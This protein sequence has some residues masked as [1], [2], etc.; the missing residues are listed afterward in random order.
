MQVPPSRL[1]PAQG[2]G[3]PPPFYLAMPPPTFPLLQRTPA[4]S[5]SASASAP[6]SGAAS[7][8]PSRLSIKDSCGNGSGSGNG[9][10]EPSPNGAARTSDVSLPTS[11]LFEP[12]PSVEPSAP[13]A[14]PSMGQRLMEAIRGRAE[15]ARSDAKDSVEGTHGQGGNN[16]N[17]LKRAVDDAA[18]QPGGK[19]VAVDPYKGE[20]D[21]FEW[22]D[23]FSHRYKT[24]V[25]LSLHDTS[26]PLLKRQMVSLQ[27]TD[28]EMQEVQHRLRSFQQRSSARR[29]R[30]ER[31][32]QLEATS[33]QLASL[34]VQ[35][36]RLLVESHAQ[37]AALEKAA[38]ASLC[39][40]V[41]EAASGQ[42]EA[43]MATAKESIS[44]AATA[45]KAAL[46]NACVVPT[47][48]HEDG[49]D[50]SDSATAIVVE[51]TTK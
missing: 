42:M 5:A 7:R 13:A 26:L 3:V 31:A 35:Y 16:H 20:H 19:R 32:Q 4:Q 43:A 22:V 11:K 6:A 30:L 39:T 25:R 40:A 15:I 10:V 24:T 29:K 45:C 38:L 36:E 41:P 2:P 44:A 23:V 48:G 17:G 28:K 14:I 51:E 46:S 33:R 49:Q 34:R 37:I 21:D 1:V 47:A 12:A 9:S 8:Q 18:M 50:C 27:V